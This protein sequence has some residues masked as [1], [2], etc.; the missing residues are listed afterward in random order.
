MLSLKNVPK[1]EIEREEHPE[2]Y[3][4]DMSSFTNPLR[5][6]IFLDYEYSQEDAIKWISEKHCLFDWQIREDSDRIIII[7]LDNRYV[8]SLIK[9][10]M[11][12]LGYQVTEEIET[13]N[14]KFKAFVF[15]QKI[16]KSI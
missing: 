13:D 4:L 7:L 8:V 2:V 10:N 16:L 11:N 3:S 12:L 1:E 15:E 5:Y 6:Y 9:G 14:E